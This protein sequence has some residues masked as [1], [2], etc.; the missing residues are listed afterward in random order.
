MPEHSLHRLATLICNGYWSNTYK[1]FVNGVY[2]N[3]S[4]FS[5]DVVV[6]VTDGILHGVHC[7]ATHSSACSMFN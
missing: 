4:S 7:K 5:L 1:G 6:I 3:S 2:D